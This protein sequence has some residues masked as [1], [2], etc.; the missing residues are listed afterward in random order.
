MWNG[1]AISCSGPPLR[2]N[3]NQAR[4]GRFHNLYNQRLR[5]R[6]RGNA[7]ARTDLTRGLAGDGHGPNF[8]RGNAVDRLSI[9]R[10]IHLLH[11]P[12]V[13]TYAVRDPAVGDGGESIGHLGGDLHGLALRK[14]SRGAQ[15]LAVH[16]FADDEIFSHVVNADDVGVVQ[17]GNGLGFLLEA[18]EAPGVVSEIVGQDFDSDVA[19][20]ARVAGL[21]DLAHPTRADGREDFVRAESCAWRKGHARGSAKFNPS[22]SGCV[23]DDSTPGGWLAEIK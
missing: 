10:G 7:A 2:G 15:G 18:L 3:S 6:V 4:I 12:F 5:G 1:P 17:S 9:G 21:V 16:Q 14:F 11:S 22:R 19:I 13:E 8:T 23:L 20:E